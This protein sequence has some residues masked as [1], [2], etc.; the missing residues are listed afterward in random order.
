MSKK[1]ER[2]SIQNLNISP[3]TRIYFYTR[4]YQAIFLN[5]QGGVFLEN[6]LTLFVRT[7]AGELCL[8]N[9]QFFPPDSFT[10]ATMSN[11]WR[12]GGDR[13]AIRNNKHAPNRYSNFCLIKDNIYVKYMH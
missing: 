9:P 4:T 2:N 1:S 7:S 13:S 3:E 11:G 8:S 6:G 5:L 12:D 10:M